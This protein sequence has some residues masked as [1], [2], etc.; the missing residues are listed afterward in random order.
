MKQFKL[1]SLAAAIAVSNIASTSFASTDISS[2]SQ[3]NYQGSHVASPEWQDQI[4]YFLMIDRF[5]DGDKSNNDQGQNE[6]DPNNDKKFIGGDIQGVTDK[7]DYLE[8]MGATAVWITPP[9]ANQWWDAEQNYGGYHGYWARD[10][11]KLDEHFGDIDTYRNLADELH[12]RDMYLIQD[13]VTNHVGNYFTYDEPHNYDPNNVCE[14]FRLIDSPLS[15]GQS[16]PYPLNQNSCKSDKTGSYNWTPSIMNHRDPVQ[17]KTWQLSDLDDLNTMDQEVRTYLK[18]SYRKWIREIGVDAFRIDTVKFVEHDFWNDFI[19]AE[20]GILN[21]AKKTGRENFLNFGE[22]FETSTPYK[23]EG[24]EKMLTYIGENGSPAQLE[25]VLN[26]PLQSTMT[27]VFAGG[28][29][30]DYLRFRLEKM[31]EMF[32]NPYVMPNFI[33]NHDMPRFLNQGSEQELKQALLT[34]LTIPG[35]PV[36]YQGTEQSMTA[37]RDAMFEGGFREDGKKI[38]SFDTQSELYTFIKTL[39]EMR[40]DN[41]VF[42][43]GD[44]NVLSS[45]KSGAGV[46]AF[47]R[48]YGDEEVLVVMNTSSSNMLLNQLELGA[49]KGTVYKNKFQANWDEAPKKLVANKEGEVT[50]ELAPKAAVIYFKTENTK[51]V[52]KSNLK[53]KVKGDWEDVTISGDTEIKGKATPNA[54]LKLVVN[55]NLDTATDIKVSKE[56]RW[57]TTLSTRHFAI[58]ENEHRFAIYSPKKKDGAEDIQFT[59]NLSWPETADIT[60]NDSGDAKDGSAGPGGSYSLPTD[61]S[62]DKVNSQLSIEKAEVFTNGSNVR[63]KLTMENFTDSWL[64]PNGFDHVGFS[65][66]IGLPAEESTGLTQLPKINH[67][68]PEGKWNRNVVVFGWQNSIFNTKGATADSRGESISSAPKVTVDKANRVIFLDFA[69][70][71]LGRPESLNDIRF[72]VTTWDLDGLSAEYRPLKQEKGAWNFAGGNSDDPKVWDDLPIIKLSEQ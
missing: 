38:S 49:D 52:K 18:E 11:K 47:T 48:T 45:D 68:M 53:V 9:V 3:N 20:D 35:I 31:M 33:D 40:T 25:S 17:E 44:I 24:E 43:R 8:N 32:S 58:G 55:G 64:S 7:L 1:L 13:I 37:D 65:I 72:Y 10:F 36:I 26:F 50:M 62:F 56:G 28:Q 54:K 29:P 21:E 22:V 67:T 51:K 63:L 70:D 5:N 2:D 19:H 27:R 61:A 23:T 41:K 14:G 39:S 34:L 42:T 71:A 57:S 59:S 69:S 4:I 60:L 15:P 30:T 6:Y 16:L 66:F 12:S 46:F